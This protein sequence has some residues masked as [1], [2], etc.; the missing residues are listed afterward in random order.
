[1]ACTAVFERSNVTI[2]GPIL[3]LRGESLDADRGSKL[4][5]LSRQHVLTHGGMGQYHAQAEL[6]SS[7]AA[8][9]ATAVRPRPRQDVWQHSWR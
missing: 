3:K 1:M 7:I 4:E 2:P 5:V 6:L 8:L 9:W